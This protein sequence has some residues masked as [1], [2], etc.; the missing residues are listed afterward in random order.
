[1]FSAGSLRGVIKGKRISFEEYR[2]VVEEREVELWDA[3][4]TEYEFEMSR[5]LDIG[6]C[7]IMAR[8]EL[9]CKKKTSCVI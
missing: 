7:R 4:L 3:N 6:G 1:V 2:T 5:V 9:S 8:R